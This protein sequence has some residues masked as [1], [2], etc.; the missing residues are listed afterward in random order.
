MFRSL[1]EKLSRNIILRQR[2]PSRV[3]GGVVFVSPDSAL[4]YWR[5]D[6]EKATKELFDFAAEFVKE[7][8]T[9]WD[10]GANVGMFTFASTFQAKSNGFVAAIESDTFCVDLLRRSASAKSEDRAKIMVLPA[11]VSDSVGIAEFHIAKR[12]R[13][14]NYLASSQDSTQTGGLRETVSVMTVTLDW[15]SDRLPPPK[16]L[17]IDVEGAETNVLRGAEQLL[18]KYKPIILCEVLEYNADACTDIFHAYG[19]SLYNF[20]N[21]GEGKI[22]RAVLDTL[23]IC[24]AP[25]KNDDTS[26]QH[27]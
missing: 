19:Y 17:K 25:P 20:R 18:S 2:L 4:R 1:L 14:V 15:L 8:D 11:A 9:V 12:G 3:G 10:V 16:V 7:G 6:L 5:W 21:R 23:A 27:R 13:S 24:E 22:N 26:S